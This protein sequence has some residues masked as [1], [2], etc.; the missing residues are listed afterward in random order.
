M[1]CELDGARQQLFGSDI[2]QMRNDER[3]EEQDT[4]KMQVVGPQLHINQWEE[5]EGMYDYSQ[6]SGFSIIQWVIERKGR[7][8]Y[9]EHSETEIPVEHEWKWWVDSRFQ[10]LKVKSRTRNIRS[11]KASALRSPRRKLNL[12]L[13]GRYPSDISSQVDKERYSSSLWT[14]MKTEQ[15]LFFT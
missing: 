15:S 10:L 13:K 6:I 9:C 8:F 3:V 1:E 7:R 14:T 11:I 12:W 4:R 2:V 5:E